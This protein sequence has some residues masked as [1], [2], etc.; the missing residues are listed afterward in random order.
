MFEFEEEQM[1]KREKPSANETPAR[2]RSIPLIIHKTRT[3]V[4]RPEDLHICGRVV[5]VHRAAN[6]YLCLQ[7]QV[8]EHRAMSCFAKR[9]HQLTSLL[10]EDDPVEFW[11]EN[12]NSN[13]YIK[14]ITLRKKILS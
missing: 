14:Q 7:I 3:E 2:S 12:G 10:L 1:E 6:N 9:D 4:I 8:S 5:K 11:L 13:F